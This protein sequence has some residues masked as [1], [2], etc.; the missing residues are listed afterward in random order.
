[1]Y[2]SVVH[3]TDNPLIRKNAIEW[4]LGKFPSDCMF[5]GNYQGYVNY[6]TR[7]ANK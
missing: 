4:D 5:L 2:A 1:M 7:D 6:K 3:E